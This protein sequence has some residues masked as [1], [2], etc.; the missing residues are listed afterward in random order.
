M[1]ESKFRAW[2][3]GQEKIGCDEDGDGGREGPTMLTWEDICDGTESLKEY[4]CIGMS[5]VSPLMQYTGLEDKKGQEYADE[6]I[7]QWIQPDY[8]SQ[9]LEKVV[10]HDGSWWIADLQSGDLILSLTAVQAGLRTII[11]N[12]Y[13][14]P[15]LAGATSDS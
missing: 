2:Y 10:W 13:E 11:G 12:T 6:D 4:F 14:N 5:D 8:T 9:R 7:M 15:E 3:S 1:R